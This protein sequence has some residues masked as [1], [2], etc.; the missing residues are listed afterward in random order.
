MTEKL[1]ALNDAIK[2]GDELDFWGNPQP[3]CPHCETIFNIQ[4]NE[5]WE[6]YKEGD[7]EIECTACELEFKVQVNV[8]FT[9]STDEQEDMDE[10]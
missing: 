10:L 2:R 3:R 5:A 6:L 8:E 9:Y 4:D 1:A 7:H